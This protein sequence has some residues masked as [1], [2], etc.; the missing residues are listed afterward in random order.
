MIRWR[1]Y[2]AEDDRALRLRHAR[3][4]EASG[5]EWAYPNFDDP[6]Y[7]VIEV[8]ERDGEVLGAVAAHATVEM[9]FVGCD[10]LT[11][12]AA[13]RAQAALRRRMTAAGCDE[14]HAFVPRRWLKSMEPLLR[15]LGFRRSNGSYEPFYREL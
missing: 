7:L 3:Q 10:P 9:M 6:R 11:A 14:V 8:A 5:V 15:R 2:R 4:C 13:V 12:R 1:P